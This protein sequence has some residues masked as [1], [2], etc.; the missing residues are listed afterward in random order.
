MGP[1]ASYISTKQTS[2]YDAPVYDAVSARNN[3]SQ[4]RK[5]ES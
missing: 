2:G 4:Q 3:E 1:K 5:E